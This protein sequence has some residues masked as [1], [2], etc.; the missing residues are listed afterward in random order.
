MCA[1]LQRITAYHADRTFEYICGTAAE[2]ET[3]DWVRFCEAPD[4]EEATM[5]VN[6]H[7]CTQFGVACPHTGELHTFMNSGPTTGSIAYQP[8]CSSTVGV[9]VDQL[10]GKRAKGDNAASQYIALC[11][12]AWTCCA[13]RPCST[14]LIR[15]AWAMSQRRNCPQSSPRCV[16]IDS[17]PTAKQH[18]LTC[19]C[20]CYRSSGSS[21]PRQSTACFAP[22]S[23]NGMAPL[24]S[25]RV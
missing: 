12:L 21:C 11:S 1:A 5:M 16:Q 25:V 3:H 20:C 6:C 2:M 22:P 23:A 19:C 13:S 9:W 14:S 15:R 7:A 18:V 4:K 10:E 24:Q 17:P 8:A